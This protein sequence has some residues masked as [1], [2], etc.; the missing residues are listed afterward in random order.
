[1]LDQEA[2]LN[3]PD[4]R[5]TNP[6]CYEDAILLPRLDS[7][8]ASLKQLAGDIEADERRTAT[9]RSR[10]RSEEFISRCS[11]DGATRPKR[12]ILAARLRLH[13]TKQVETTA[14]ASQ[15][16]STSVPK[17]RVNSTEII[18]M[19]HSP[20]LHRL[21]SP[22]A[23]SRTLHASSTSEFA[24]EP[25]QQY[26]NLAGRSPYAPRRAHNSP[27]QP[28]SSSSDINLDGR[29][30]SYCEIDAPEEIVIIENH[31]RSTDSVNPVEPMRKISCTS[32][33][34]SDSSSSSPSLGYAA[35][36]GELI[37]SS[38][39]EDYTTFTKDEIQNVRRSQ[40]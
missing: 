23:I 36:G 31:Y 27:G 14:P 24:I 33:E 40:F 37:N 34:A 17:P 11:D 19:N 6:P 1:M 2:Q 9:K 28:S 20:R 5:E 32:S 13:K 7:S 18:T 29:E 4:P 39:S 35:K 38:S 26:M 3:A 22:N 30:P 12:H 25:E 16:P 8:F 10:S 21:H 15:T